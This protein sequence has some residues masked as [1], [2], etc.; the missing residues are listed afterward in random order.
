MGGANTGKREY[1]FLTRDLLNAARA[2][3]VDFFLA[4][5][6]KLDEK[7]TY[8]SEK[9]KKFKERKLTSHELLTWAESLSVSTEAHPDPLEGWNFSEKFPGMPVAYRRSVIKDAIGKVRSYLSNYRNWEKTGKKKGKPG[10]PAPRNH[11]TLYRGAMKLDLEKLDRQRNFVA[12]LVW[13]GSEWKWCNYPVKFSP[14]QEKRL[15][16]A[17]WENESPRLILKEK[18]AELHVT[19]TKAV[20][21][22]K[23]KD[24]Q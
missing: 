11:P 23:V 9:D 7:V 19:Q 2:F 1:L 15:I 14:W 21:A 10:L 8:W 17:G 24:L 16:E 22:K 12:I 13:T 20:E 4:H 18:T 6:N 5:S 3:Y